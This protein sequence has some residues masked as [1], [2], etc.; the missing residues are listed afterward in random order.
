M[1]DESK[2]WRDGRKGVLTAILVPSFY[3]MDWVLVAASASSFALLRQ[4]GVPGWQVWLLFWGAN[5]LISGAVVLFHNRSGIDI[6]LMQS[7]RG[8]IDRA[9]G[10]SKWTGLALETAIFIRL[11]LWDGPC[12][13]LIFFQ[14]RLSTPGVRVCFLVAASAFQM[15]VWTGLYALGYESIS[16]LVQ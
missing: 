13:L 10:R 9:A 4:S 11:L 1:A 2:D 16:E 14:Q 7:L 3:F 15:L 5:L 8:L 12:Q 6:T